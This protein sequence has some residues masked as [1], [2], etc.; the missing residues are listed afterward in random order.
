[1][2]T[3]D[4]SV[5]PRGHGGKFAT[6][7]HAE[8]AALEPGAPTDVS[9]ADADAEA[10]SAYERAVSAAVRAVERVQAEQH[11]AELRQ[12]IARMYPNAVQLTTRAE[13]DGII[14]LTGYSDADGA[15]V[16]LDYTHTGYDELNAE[17]R[18]A[19]KQGHFGT[20]LRRSPV[21]GTGAIHLSRMYPAVRS[22][23]SQ[24]DAMQRE[25]DRARL[26]ADGASLKTRFLA[27]IPDA[28]AVHVYTAWGQD[29]QVQ[30]DD[31]ELAD[32]TVIALTDLKDRYG[33]RG[34]DAARII[35]NAFARHAT[36]RQWE[37][38]TRDGIPDNDQEPAVVHFD[39]LA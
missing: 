31:V 12:I 26:A 22:A 1:M 15:H 29:D 3:F 20:S 19:D 14:G 28:K 9:I 38:W 5:H 4:Q 16:P 8:P 33:D 32:G 30:P 21:D 6:K 10:E 24:L 11:Q 17:L 2:T 35:E 25:I 39:D 18:L 34:V 27:R 7:Q 23:E 36:G 37:Q 13:E